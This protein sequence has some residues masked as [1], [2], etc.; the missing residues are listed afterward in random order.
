[1]DHSYLVEGISSKI[2]KAEYLSED[3]KVSYKKELKDIKKA[4]EKNQAGKS[5]LLKSKITEDEIQKI[6]SR[7]TGVPVTKMAEGE[8]TKILKMVQ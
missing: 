3:E 8:R 1:M 5:S 6:V 2:D 7:L 4:F